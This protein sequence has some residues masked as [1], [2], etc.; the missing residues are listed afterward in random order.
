MGA[1]CCFVLGL[2]L[3][4]ISVYVLATEIFFYHA[5]NKVEATI[6]EVRHQHVPAGRG[7]ILAYVPIVELPHTGDRIE[8]N[9]SSV[10]NVYLVGGRLSLL[11]DLAASKQCIES[12]FFDVWWGLVELSLSLLLLVPS[13]LYLWRQ[14]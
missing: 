10:E 14:R 5:A 13:S 11:C 8:V 4:P 7:S 3:L 12:G 1:I 2:L 6:V 9:T